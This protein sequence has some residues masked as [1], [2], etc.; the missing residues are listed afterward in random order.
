MTNLNGQK[1]YHYIYKTT[2]LINDKFYVGMHSTN[3]L[4]DGYLGSGKKL[5]Y[6]IRKYGIEKFKIEYLEFFNNRIDLA[7]REKQLVNEDLLKDP[8]CMNL[9][10]GG[11]GGCQGE[12][13]MKWSKAGIAKIKWLFENEPNFRKEVNQATSIRTKLL[14]ESGKF[15]LHFNNQYWLGK[16]HREESKR[17]IGNANSV[18]QKGEANSQ[19]GTCWI[20]NGIEN[21]KIKKTDSIPMGWKLG[22]K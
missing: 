22:R 20:T 21:K 13:A 3:N 2:N 16:T 19:F 4:K 18:K 14:W 10:N 15:D 11:N 6:S 8:M 7:N 5:R 1:K 17:K 9:K 12:A